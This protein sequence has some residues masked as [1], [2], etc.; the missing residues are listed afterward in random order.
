M[1]RMR[2]C[3]EKSEDFDFSQE[4]TGFPLLETKLGSHETFSHKCINSAQK[5]FIPWSSLEHFL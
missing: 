4:E 3:K 2:I 1:K 5:A